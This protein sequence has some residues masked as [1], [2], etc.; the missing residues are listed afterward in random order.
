MSESKTP[1][2]AWPVLVSGN[3]HETTA[4][5]WDVVFTAAPRATPRVNP[6]APSKRR[7]PRS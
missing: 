1:V 7:T 5:G 4:S 2:P 3:V 6:P